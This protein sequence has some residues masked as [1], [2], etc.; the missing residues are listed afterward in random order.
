M[1]S[2]DEVGHTF[3]EHR[4][5]SKRRVCLRV[6]LRRIGDEIEK[7]QKAF[8]R[9]EVTAQVA[10]DTSRRFGADDGDVVAILQELASASQQVHR[11]EEALRRQGMGDYIPD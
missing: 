8:D 6:K 3:S 10:A 9:P 5:Q 2:D 4:A 1:T 7:V 11:L